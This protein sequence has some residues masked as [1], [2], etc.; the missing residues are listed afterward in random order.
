MA[1]ARFDEVKVPFE[2][3]RFRWRY[4]NLL[5]SYL[6]LILEICQDKRSWLST[7]LIMMPSQS[8]IELF[9]PRRS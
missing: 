8:T 5:P 6:D 9:P 4:L 3:E 7:F 2:I 1:V